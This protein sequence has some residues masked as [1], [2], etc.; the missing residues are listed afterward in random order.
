MS[1]TLP[2]MADEAVAAA[3]GRDWAG[4]RALLDGEGAAGMAHTDIVPLV[5]AHGVDGWWGQTVTV[6]YERMIGRRAPGQRCA[7]DF[8]AS[9]SRTLTGD[10]DAAM[11]RWRVLADGAVDFAGA[12]AEGAPRL[13]ETANWRYWKIDLED[14]SRATVMASDKADGKALLL[15]DHEKLGDAEAA[16]RAKAFWKDMLAKA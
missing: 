6:G 12:L 16:A 3:T 10:K 4:W 13:S 2:G 15:V 11:A 1:E 8:A 14:G 7:G 9:A 5:A